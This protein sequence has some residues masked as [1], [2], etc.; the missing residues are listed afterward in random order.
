M[1][2]SL[3]AATWFVAMAGPVSAS[4]RPVSEVL[5]LAPDAL[6][7]FVEIQDDWLEWLSAVAQGDPTRAS[8]SLD[9]LVDDAE[10]LG[11]ERLPDLSLGAAGR[12]I[13]FAED[14]RFDTAA[15]CLL[16]AERLDPGR[17]EVAFAGARVAQM[18]GK[19][20]A[21]VSRSM[22]GYARLFQNRLLRR[23]WRADLLH[24]LLFV[25]L[26]S[27][28]FYVA[29]MMATTGVELFHDIS[30]YVG[31][32]VPN[33]VAVVI[34]LVALAWP[35][36]LPAG[37][38][39][40][41]VY[42]SILLWG[43]GQLSHKVI[44]VILWVVL[45]AAPILIN[46]QR[47]RIRVALAP[48]VLSIESLASG[49]LRGSLFSD[50]AS[51]RV[52]L[53][54]SAAVAHL[55]ADLHIRLGEWD[56]ARAL[57]ESLIER[58]PGSG[59][60]L[61]NLGVCHLEQGDQAQA[62]AHFQR[63]AETADGSAAARFNMSQVLS[64]LYRFSEA[65][66]ELRIAQQAAPQRVSEWLRQAANRRAIVLDGGLERTDEIREQLVASWRSEEVGSRW[67]GL[68]P[69]VLSLPMAIVFLVIAAGLHLVVRRTERAPFKPGD[70][71]APRGS[72][73]SALLVG[74]AELE[75]ER[76][77]RGFVLILLLVVLLSLPRAAEL[78]YRLPW[79]FGPGAG[80]ASA[81]AA[82]GLS[83]FVL[84][85]LVR[86]LRGTL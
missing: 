44:L 80:L 13:A 47:Q 2:L 45:G 73:R 23:L 8:A 32:Y 78:G 55:V 49:E 24:W 11:L 7:R 16:A 1:W 68:W 48:T 37:V 39:W 85:R 29:L 79:I 26:A 59:S 4:D 67:S 84:I 65:E 42:W 46:E 31:R 76:P 60:A 43:Y 36:L 82:T 25:V 33:S 71:L 14:D 10:I 17:S 41:L 38:F 64:E 50:L 30:A 63:A 54:D 20:A 22:E 81:V 70:R 56:S 53:P 66:R 62:M 72:W 6:S 35:L 40:L 74:F 83:I 51:L 5:G 12:A 77:I 52:A 28:A 69:R 27:G 9:N 3:A 19:W 18:E 86:Y 61:L 75:D 15:Q 34:T 57:Y 58:E 21:V